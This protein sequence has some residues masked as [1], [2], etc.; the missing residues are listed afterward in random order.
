MKPPRITLIPVLLAL[1]TVVPLVAGPLASYADFQTKAAQANQVLCVPDYP[2]TPEALG[3]QTDATIK[4][5]DDALA[6][7]VAQDPAKADF[8]ST[9]AAYDDIT[10]AAGIFNNQVYTLGQSHPD[11]AMRDMANEQSSKLDTWSIGLEYREDIY[12]LLQAYADTKPRLDARQQRLLEFTLRDFRRAGLSLPAVERQ[13]VEE[14]RKVLAELEQQFGININE[15]RAPLD[16]TAEEMKGV[17]DSFLE[18]P[19]VKQPDGTYRVM[20]NITWHYAAVASHADSADVRRRLYLAR[21]TLARDKNIP[22]LAKIVAL[23]AE[24]AQRLGY[25]NWADYKTEIKMAKTG[26]TALK[27][28]NDLVDG[29]EPKF[30]Q[31]TETLRQMKATQLSQPDAQLEPWDTGYYTDRLKKEKFAVDTEALRVYF[32]YEAVLRGMFGIYQDIFGLKFTEV[33]PP[34]T[35]APGVKLFVVEDSATKELLGQFYLD[36]FPREGKYNHFANFPQQQGR[37]LP[38]GKFEL[39]LAA[40][41]CNFPPP[42]A[43]KPSLLK[44]D[45]V[46]TLF[47]EFGHVMHNVLGRAPYVGLLSVPRDFVEAPS[48]MLENWVWDKAV[49]DTFAAD[50]RDPSKKIPAETIAAMVQARQATEGR[51]TRGQLAYG[52]IDMGLHSLS[53]DDAWKAD[54]VKQSN[55]VLARVTGTKDQ[56]TAFVAYFG[57]L[58]GYDAGYYGYLWSLVMAQDMAS[59]FRAAPHGFLDVETGRRLRQ[60]VYSVGNTRDVGDSVEA[61]LGRPRSQ[62]AF[63]EHVGIKK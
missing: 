16:F 30:T 6:A 32:P 12:R 4:T 57:H 19:G 50:Y 46:Q 62:E 59:I 17:A 41:L 48:Q 55:D 36:M 44:H 40:L 29:L 49:L 53:V 47:H 37:L 39:P 54:V 31:E 11:K 28:E 18:S 43:D 21:N 52:L 13:R 14:L 63:L 27:F 38:G 15:A 23:R 56:G 10:Y 42:S 33:E 7:L 35:W 8:A 60:A 9:F 51:L 61:F 25:A 58:N 34:Y 3:S 26:A 5:A 24:V 1:T 45:D 20:A 22:V 2:K